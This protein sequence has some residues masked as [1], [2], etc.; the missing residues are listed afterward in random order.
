MLQVLIGGNGVIKIHNVKLEFGSIATPFVPP[1]PTLELLK[2]QRYYFSLLGD[3]TSISNS[4]V[5]IAA[6]NTRLPLGFIFPTKMR[7]IPTTSIS[8]LAKWNTSTNNENTICNSTYTS[9]NGVP[10]LYSENGEFVAGTTYYLRFST[11]AEIY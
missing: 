1:D 3:E 2:C 9:K 5:G 6:N 11:D 8:Y 10:V 7:A 4:T